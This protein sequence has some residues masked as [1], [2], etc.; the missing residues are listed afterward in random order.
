MRNRFPDNTDGQFL[1]DALQLFVHKRTE[2]ISGD[3]SS[4]LANLRSAYARHC[5][6]MALFSAE[7]PFFA[8]ANEAAQNFQ[9]N[10]ERQFKQ[11]TLLQM[12]LDGQF[13]VQLVDD[14][15]ETHQHHHQLQHLHH[16][17][18]PVVTGE[19]FQLCLEKLMRLTSRLGSDELIGKILATNEALLK[20]G[21]ETFKAEDGTQRI[22]VSFFVIG[23]DF[24]KVVCVFLP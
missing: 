12:G 15:E 13:C 24:L 19:K 8:R 18:P 10:L 7:S 20:L 17:V 3:P 9:Q 16:H 22:A 4:F 23:I 21:P 11:L 6:D 1:L 14:E 2:A 5:P